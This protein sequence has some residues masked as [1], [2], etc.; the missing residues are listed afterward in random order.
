MEREAQLRVRASQLTSEANGTSDE[1]R[2][3][4]LLRMAAHYVTMAENENWLIAN[5]MSV[6][7][8][9]KAGTDEV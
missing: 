4:R 1:E 7:L 8:A 9:P 3:D 5:S 2:K 6:P